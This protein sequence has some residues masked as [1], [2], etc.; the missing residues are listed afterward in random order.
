[1]IFIIGLS[2][3][4]EHQFGWLGEY[5]QEHLPHH[6]KLFCKKKYKLFNVCTGS[7][8]AIDVLDTMPNGKVKL[9]VGMHLFWDRINAHKDYFYNKRNRDMFGRGID[10]LLW[11]DAPWEV[12]DITSW[13][14][15][16]GGELRRGR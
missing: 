6:F 4:R 9:I 14:W 10:V 12:E 11:G 7:D 15:F 16:P 13:K 1:M 8:D 2:D 3:A 5:L